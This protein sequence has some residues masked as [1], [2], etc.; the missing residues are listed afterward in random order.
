MDLTHLCSSLNL[1]PSIQDHSE[2]VHVIKLYLDQQRGSHKREI[3]SSAQSRN[4]IKTYQFRVQVIEMILYELNS[5]SH[6][7][8]IEFIWDVPAERSKL[9]TLLIM[10][11]LKIKKCNVILLFHYAWFRTM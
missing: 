2:M 11:K 5:S 8:L 10:K 3:R 9:S 4:M 1:V 6:V 7:S